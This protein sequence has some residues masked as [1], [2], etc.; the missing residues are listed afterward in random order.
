MVADGTKAKGEVLAAGV[1]ESGFGDEYDDED[2][3]EGEGEGDEG[4]FDEE[5]EDG[6]FE[7]EDAED[8]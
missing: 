4:L 8:E 5:D 2:E 1:D 7:A 3:E 6:E